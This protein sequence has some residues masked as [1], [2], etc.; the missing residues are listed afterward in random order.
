MSDLTREEMLLANLAGEPVDTLPDP[1]TREEIF[2][3]SMC[4]CYD[5]PM[6]E[7]RT[8]KELYLKSVCDGGAG[9]GGG[10][11]TPTGDI[12]ITENGE[13]DVTEFAKAIV[14]VAGGGGDL[15][16]TSGTFTLSEEI[17]VGQGGYYDINH[18]LGCMP[19]LFLL[20]LEKSYASAY[21]IVNM[22]LVENSSGEY[23]LSLSFM[24]PDPNSRTMFSC[25]SLSRD[26]TY[27]QHATASNGFVA[28]IN[29]VRVT[30]FTFS[31][32]ASATLGSQ[33]KYNWIA[34]G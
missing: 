33:H 31:N 6:P 19:R 26:G 14:N 8:R 1:R 13:F 18:N 27:I 15:K 3:A 21:K 32:Y 10:G 16:I 34:I 5:G 29:V 28:D 22:C 9:S 24:Y 2:L 20:V 12:N 11:I 7:P 4:R 30:T 23:H 25:A 17:S